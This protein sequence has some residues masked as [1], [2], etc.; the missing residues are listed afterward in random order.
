MLL[1][2]VLVAAM[3]MSAPQPSNQPLDASP[4]SVFDSN[5]PS[6][7]CTN[8]SPAL[9]SESSGGSS[10]AIAQ[11]NYDAVYDEYW[12]VYNNLTAAVQVY[13]SCTENC[14]VWEENAN[15]WSSYFGQMEYALQYAWFEV[16]YHCGG[17]S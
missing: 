16:S 6:V 1:K 17:G 4:I 3:T 14:G 2:A 15:Y 8:E 10:C 12:Y 13:Q 5:S 11:A 9:E 7:A